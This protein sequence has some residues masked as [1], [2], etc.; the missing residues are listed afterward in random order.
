ML[1]FN[2][3]LND[4]SESLAVSPRNRLSALLSRF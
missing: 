3:I 4:V 2:R 1:V